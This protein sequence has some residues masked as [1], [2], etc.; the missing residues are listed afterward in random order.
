MASTG[1][2]GLVSAFSRT[3]GSW[4]S[5]RI[6][7]R[8]MRVVNR[9]RGPLPCPW[10]SPGN[11]GDEMGGELSPVEPGVDRAPRAC[12]AALRT[13]RCTV[14]RVLVGILTAS[15]RWVPA[16][17]PHGIATRG[18]YSRARGARTGPGDRDARHGW[19]GSDEIPLLT[20]S[21]YTDARQRLTGGDGCSATARRSRGSRPTT[22]PQPASSTVRHS[23]S[24]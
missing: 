1:S 15:T 12:V 19:T 16:D 11:A 4:I 17:V 2:P 18:H 20:E 10:R 5:P 22:S 23:D 3:P 13:D 21:Q 24:T 6:T 7:A 9:R 8:S 14:R